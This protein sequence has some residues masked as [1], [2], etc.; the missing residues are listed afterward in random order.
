M[1]YGFDWNESSTRRGV[2]WL[3][4]AIIGFVMVW[5]GRDVSQLLLL[6][7]GVSGGIGLI[8]KDKQE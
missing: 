3:V 4:S 1:K 7:A 8:T 5:Q 2:V 6:A